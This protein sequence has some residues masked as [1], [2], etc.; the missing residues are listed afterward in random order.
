MTTPLNRIETAWAT[1]DPLALHREVERLAAE[2]HSRQALENALETLL[3]AVRA[4]GA[5]DDTEEIINGVWDR[6]TGWCHTDQHIGTLSSLDQASAVDAK[7]P[8]PLPT[9]SPLR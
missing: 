3:L 5:G 9:P 6:L 7:I 4:T 8:T 1:G 2:G